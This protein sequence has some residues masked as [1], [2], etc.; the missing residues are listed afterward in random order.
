MHESTEFLGQALVEEGLITRDQLEQAT[1]LALETECTLDEAIETLAL[2]P[3][4]RIALC[5]AHICEAAY[6]DLSQYEINLSNCRL[7]PRTA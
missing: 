2:V 5:K 6:V 3:A 7:I 1:A 4:S